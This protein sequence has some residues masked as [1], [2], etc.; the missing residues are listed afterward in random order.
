[1]HG[2][3]DGGV[4]AVP[5]DPETVRLIDFF[6]VF[7]ASPIALLPLADQDR[8]AF[9]EPIVERFLGGWHTCHQFIAVPEEKRLEVAF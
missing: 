1:M 5:R 6:T 8:D 3:P 2:C 4:T 9:G 7:R